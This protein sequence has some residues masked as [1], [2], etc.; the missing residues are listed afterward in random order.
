MSCTKVTDALFTSVPVASAP[1]GSGSGGAAPATAADTV[2]AIRW[3][4][5]K[6]LTLRVTSITDQTVRSLRHIVPGLT[7]LDLHWCRLVSDRDLRDLRP[8]PLQRL[9]LSRCTRVK[10]WGVV[11]LLKVSRTLQTVVLTGSGVEPA[12]R[13]KLVSAAKGRPVMIAV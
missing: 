12:E 2:A 5:L 10:V 8:V 4:P 3:P 1:A 6:S 13:T 9:V 11:D 7:C